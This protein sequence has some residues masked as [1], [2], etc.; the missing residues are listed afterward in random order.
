MLQEAEQSIIRYEKC[1]EIF[2]KKLKSEANMVK[3]G[4]VCGYSALGKDS[5]QVS[6]PAFATT[7]LFLVTSE[8]LHPLVGDHLASASSASPSICSLFKLR[9]FK[10]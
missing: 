4:A 7:A 1:N 6:S 3:K 2:K 10:G 8:V 5:C 9:G